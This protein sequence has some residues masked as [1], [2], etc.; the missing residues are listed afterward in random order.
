LFD[1]RIAQLFIPR[2]V[3]GHYSLKILSAVTIG[4]F[5]SA[6]VAKLPNLRHNRLLFIVAGG[7]LGAIGAKVPRIAALSPAVLVGHSAFS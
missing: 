4:S 7:P 1:R 5:G 6:L 3:C 2:S